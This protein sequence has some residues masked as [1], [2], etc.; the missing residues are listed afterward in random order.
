MKIL[1]IFSG[2]YTPLTRGVMGGIFYEQHA[3]NLLCRDTL[4]EI[5]VDYI[6]IELKKEKEVIRAAIVVSYASPPNKV[7]PSGIDD[8]PV[9]PD[10]SYEFFYYPLLSISSL[11]TYWRSKSILKPKL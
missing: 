5:I 9:K 1:V 2:L 3:V 6:I 7:V 11:L 8:P 10:H 4:K